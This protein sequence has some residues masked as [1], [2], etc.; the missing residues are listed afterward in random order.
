ML[1]PAQQG[2]HAAASVETN[3]VCGYPTFRARAATIAALASHP[4]TQPHIKHLPS[5]CL[6]VS[7]QSRAQQPA[8]LQCAAT[9]LCDLCSL[10]RCGSQPQIQLLQQC[11]RRWP[12]VQL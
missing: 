3:S 8:A 11:K 6:P 1:C 9:H 7:D 10:V 4:Q 2:S 12:A 5:C